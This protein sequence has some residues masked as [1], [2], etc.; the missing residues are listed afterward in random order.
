[1][2]AYGQKRQVQIA[3]SL[4][5]KDLYGSQNYSNLFLV[6]LSK[7]DPKKPPFF[8][9]LYNTMCITYSSLIMFG[10]SK[11]LLARELKYFNLFWPLP[12]W[13]S[14]KFFPGTINSSVLLLVM[15]L[16]QLLAKLIS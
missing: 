14:L 10:C 12:L 16:S 4:L 1:M 2:A 15:F 11:S 8:L 9:A 5:F 7:T 13:S 3:Q 6:T